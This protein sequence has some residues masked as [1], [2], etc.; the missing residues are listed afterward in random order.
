[1]GL[2]YSEHNT[3]PTQN[4]LTALL[5]A[6]TIDGPAAGMGLLTGATVTHML[7]NWEDPAV[8][9]HRVL[10]F[11]GFLM[12]SGMVLASIQSAFNRSASS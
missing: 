5:D 3:P 1:M 12:I 6:L 9:H 7:K 2:V 11:S 10:V 4:S 8:A